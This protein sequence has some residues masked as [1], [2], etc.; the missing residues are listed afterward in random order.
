M[1]TN[2]ELIAQLKE[3]LD[4]VDSASTTIGEGIAAAA[5]EQKSLFDRLTA[6]IAAGQ[7]PAALQALVDEASATLPK[8]DAA[9]AALTPLA[10]DPVN[11]VPV[12]PPPVG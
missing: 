10:A 6:A 12:E 9:V 3:A 8:L 4:R 5:A 11:P 7:D 2:Q 1:P